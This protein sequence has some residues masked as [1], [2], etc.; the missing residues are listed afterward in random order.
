MISLKTKQKYKLAM[1]CKMKDTVKLAQ[2]INTSNS[3]SMQDNETLP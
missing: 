3:L 2:L 1:K